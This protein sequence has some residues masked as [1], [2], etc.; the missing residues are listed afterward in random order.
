MSFNGVEKVLSVLIISALAAGTPISTAAQHDHGGHA[1]SPPRSETPEAPARPYE[2]PKP[3]RTV[4][5]TV[6]AGGFVPNAV[7]VKRGERVR[8]VLL[9][10][11]DDTCAREFI[12]D[13]FLV[14]K[15]LPLNEAVA[16]TFTTGRTGAFG[17]RCLKGTVTGTFNVVD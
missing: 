5:I 4:E 1:P 2:A 13:E 8:L 12:L 11:T 3:D 16:D 7:T 14:W 17:F 15:R 10:R 9:R 6:T